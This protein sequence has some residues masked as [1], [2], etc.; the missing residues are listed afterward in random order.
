MDLSGKYVLMCMKTKEIQDLGKR[1]KQNVLKRF[2]YGDFYIDESGDYYKSGSDIW[3]PKQDQL[4]AMLSLQ[5]DSIHGMAYGLYE[6]I[7][8]AEYEND[9][10]T[11]RFESFEQLWL[12]YIMKEIYDKYWNNEE[13]MERFDGY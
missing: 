10:N 2:D 7:K 9:G 4:Q 8:D 12:G 11:K 3:L 6:F 1:S 5:I 13:W